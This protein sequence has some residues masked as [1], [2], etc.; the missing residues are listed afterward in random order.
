VTALRLVQLYISKAH[1][2]SS[3]SRHSYISRRPTSPFGVLLLLSSVCVASA[4]ADT[5]RLSIIAQVSSDWLY[6]GTTETAGEPVIGFNAEWQLSNTWFSGV[7]AHE[8]NV[9][10]ARQRQRSLMAYLGRGFELNKAWFLTATVQHRE[11]PGGLKEWDFTEFAVDFSHRSGFGVSIDYA[12]DYYEHSVQ[13][14]AT[15]FR[16]SD[17]IK[18]NNYWYAQVGALILWDDPWLGDDDYQFAQVGVGSSI[19]AINLDVAYHWNSRG[20]SD[21]FAGARFS[22]PQ[23]I[24][25][26]VYKLR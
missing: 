13:A 26:L 6:H 12:P 24:V 14:A 8:G 3:R 21:D 17:S 15:E 23:F 19:G 20:E 22:D 9:D 7:E 18:G 11:F 5:P 2:L 25:Q 10:G 16:Y 4:H 1:S